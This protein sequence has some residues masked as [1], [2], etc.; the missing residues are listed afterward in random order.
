MD[1]PYLA[2]QTDIVFAHVAKKNVHSPQGLIARE[3]GNDVIQ[4][5]EVRE[6]RHRQAPVNRTGRN[7]L[8]AKVAGDVLL[9]CKLVKSGGPLPVEI[10]GQDIKGAGA[11]GVNL[12]QVQ[13][14]A[15][16]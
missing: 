13:V 2:P 11:E 10:R 6:L 3:G 14:L 7:S 4:P 12:A 1:P 16:H 8:N 5:R 15:A 9:V